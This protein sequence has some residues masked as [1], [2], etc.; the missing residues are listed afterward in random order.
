MYTHIMYH[1]SVHLKLTQYCKPATTEKE[2]SLYTD[3]PNILMS[4]QQYINLQLESYLILNI[5]FCKNGQSKHL[6][7]SLEPQISARERTTTT[8]KNI[9]GTGLTQSGRQCESQKL[10]F[11]IFCLILYFLF[12]LINFR[13]I[14]REFYYNFLLKLTPSLNMF[15]ING[16]KTSLCCMQTTVSWIFPGGT[17]GKIHLPMHT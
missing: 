16:K 13:E 2:K 9:A 17:S 4:P 3:M 5:Q 10:N 14:S 6:T 8:N 11:N 12:S 1:F 7:H 15:L